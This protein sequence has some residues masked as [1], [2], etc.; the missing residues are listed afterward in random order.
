M[1]AKAIGNKAVTNPTDPRA[2]AAKAKR[3]QT[4]AI[5]ATLLSLGGG[6]ATYSLFIAPT[7]TEMEQTRSRLTSL[8]NEIQQA[9]SVRDRLPSLR[10]DNTRLKRELQAFENSFPKEEDLPSLLITLEDLAKTHR[11]TLGAFSRTASLEKG[12]NVKQV[13]LT[14]TAEGSF[15]N[16]YSFM[17]DIGSQQR[18]L[19]IEKPELS[20]KDKGL[21]TTNLTVNAFVLMEG[22]NS[23]FP[24]PTPGQ[25]PGMPGTPEA[26]TMPTEKGPA[27]MAAENV[28]A[29]DSARDAAMEGT[30]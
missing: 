18:Y 25:I 2:N 26:T 9:M 1:T 11:V 13:A 12:S 23:A 16:L 24:P 19:S 4:I 5:I 6:A 27:G 28:K 22:N 17:K 29:Q 21:M 7:Q 20:I 3:M 15:P 10:S 8:D 14:T 30:Q